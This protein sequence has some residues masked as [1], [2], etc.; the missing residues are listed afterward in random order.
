MQEAKTDSQACLDSVV[1]AVRAA[2]G[3]LQRKHRPRGEGE[4]AVRRVLDAGLL[5]LRQEGVGGRVDLAAKT[6][7][8]CAVRGTVSST[9]WRAHP[10]QK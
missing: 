3:H 10:V 5:Q 4:E 2:P 1:V 7:N 9:G 8:A 6:R